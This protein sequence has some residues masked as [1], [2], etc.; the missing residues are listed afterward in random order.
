MK[1]LS[2]LLGTNRVIKP[3]RVFLS[4][5]SSVRANKSSE[6]DEF[7]TA[8]NQST[9]DAAGLDSSAFDIV[10]NIPEAEEQ[11]EKEKAFRLQVE[12]LRDVS[13]FPMISAALK[14]K[15]ALPTY[16]NIEDCRFIRNDPKY[17]RKAYAKHGRASGIEPGL[18]WPDKIELNEI[19]KQEK[20]LEMSFEQKINVYIE[21]RT[22]QMNTIEKMEKDTD[23]ALKKMPK[24]IETFYQRTL[25]KEEAVKEKIAKRQEILDQAREYYG[26]EVDLR[27]SRIQEMIKKLQ[28]EKKA[29]ER[30]KKKEEEKKKSQSNLLAQK[31]KESEK[32]I[33][34]LQEKPTA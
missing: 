17:F 29:A 32:L 18:A 11:M 30:Q 5:S 4:A 9:N 31:L 27:D 8:S 14:H 6:Q 13:R 2:Q 15:K 3:F 10:A 1:Y 19:M 33:K 20:E 22:N 24:Q 23:E 12:S 16:G 28:E 25:K 26:F 7:N 21:R 34:N